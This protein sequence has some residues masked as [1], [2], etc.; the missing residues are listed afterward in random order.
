M[1]SVRKMVLIGIFLVLLIPIKVKAIELDLPELYS[2]YALVYDLTQD[3]VL[4]ARNIDEK[5][6]IA[7]LT[8][9]LTSITAIEKI[10][11]LD[12][13]VVITKEMLKGIHFNASVAGLKEGDEVT[14]LDLLYASL[15]PSGADATQSLAI[16]LCGSIDNFV[17]EMNNMAKKIGMN[18]SYFK[19]TSGLDIT[20][21][22]S[23]AN[24]VLKLLKYALDNET[25]R[26]VFTTKSYVLTNGL[27][28]LSTIS[29]YEQKLEIDAGRI[30]G[31]KTGFT[32]YAGL[33]LAS[34]VNVGNEEILIITINAPYIRDEFYNLKDHLTIIDYM[35]SNYIVE[36]EPIDDIEIKDAIPDKREVI[37]N[38][39]KNY[40]N[41]LVI[42]GMFGGVFIILYIRKRYI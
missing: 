8:K 14:Y 3:E 5:T 40:K 39:S 19:N 30:L 11:N 2:K 38:V 25:F 42:G 7:S 36:E 20:G 37:I 1:N 9:I 23:T 18:N 21:Q 32:D 6:P 24:D 10:N 12:E 28:V 27:E 26:E 35:D 33:C 29:G 15:L 34:L 17:L 4:Y 22:Y 16:S 13:K 41:Y 31:S